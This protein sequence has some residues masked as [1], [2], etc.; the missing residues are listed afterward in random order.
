MLTI[1][2]FHVSYCSVIHSYV[3]GD[4]SILHD[5][6]VQ[7]AKDIEAL[8][9]PPETKDKIPFQRSAGELSYFI[10]TR[11]GRGP[12]LLTEEDALISSE[13]GFPK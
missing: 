5:A 3:L 4:N 10:C 2:Q 12:M 6:G 11:P 7:S 13:T 9:P 8:Q 1:E